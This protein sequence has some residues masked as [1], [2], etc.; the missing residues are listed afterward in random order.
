MTNARARGG[1]VVHF[2]EPACRR[3]PKKPSADGSLTR[4]IFYHIYLACILGF[5]VVVLIPRTATGG[6]GDNAIFS[7]SWVVL[8]VLSLVAFLSLLRRQ[9]PRNLIVVCIIGAYILISAAW[10][11]A[12]AATLTYGTMLVGNILV[13]H[14]IASELSLRDIVRM[15]GRIVLVL[16]LLGIVAYYMGYSQVYYIDNHE[17]MNILG[18]MP[19][20]G[21]FAH[22]IMGSLYATIG[23][24]AVLTTTRG[25]FRIACVSMLALF[26]ALTGSAT[27]I[28]LFI[29]AIILYGVV[30]VVVGAGARKS[31]PLAVI[32]GML[33]A[34]IGVA[35]TN[36]QAILQSLN[37]DTTL[38]GRTL[39]WESGLRVWQD[40]P[41]LGWGYDAY[42]NS[43]EGSL[44]RSD[45]RALGDYD[46]P[47]FHQSFIQT[48]VD[49]GVV[50]L[51]IL[52]YIFGYVLVAS[53]RRAVEHGDSA[54]AFAFVATT[55][56]GVAALTMFLFLN[57]NHFATFTMFLLFFALRRMRD[58]SGPA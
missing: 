14:M 34:A 27:G 10:S 21:F 32:G 7:M 43:P 22:K 36:W 47:H 26:V 58:S 40:R 42:F 1:H 56:M 8:H 3:P 52:V 41:I 20:R 31:H 9:D 37:R 6:V 4:M 2:R 25:L 38:T 51:A 30:G 24:V 29:L 49:L 12:P 53:Y 28:L 57:Y 15:I 19:L 44:A 35:I 23:A 11:V 5:N 45:L 55:V 13:A 50:G 17:R 33:A 39:L 48:A 54:G 16:C 46:V 18:S